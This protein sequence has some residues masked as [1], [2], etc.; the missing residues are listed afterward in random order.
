[1]DNLQTV[2]FTIKS[3]T[4]TQS[5]ANAKQNGIPNTNT[6]IIGEGNEITPD[7]ACSTLQINK[8]NYN[9]VLIH[10]QVY[11]Q[12]GKQG[13]WYKVDAQQVANQLGLST[14]ASTQLA[15]MNSYVGLINSGK[16]SDKGYETINGMKLRHINA[17]F[18]KKALQDL[19]NI[20]KNTSISGVNVGEAIKSVKAFNGEINAWIDEKS[21][22][23]YR[24][25]VKLDSKVDLAQTT[26][27]K[28]M[29]ATLENTTL[30][31]SKFNQ[32]VNIQA[33]TG[34]TPINNLNGLL[35]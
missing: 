30:D 15:D 8:Q 4:Q 17:L 23:V 26:G 33:P 11:V 9:E 28:G 35:Q 32:K 5:D 27:Q 18:D 2:H 24:T 14:L 21:G 10:N 3:S 29:I 31:L 12:Q 22:Y 16:I 6:A 34:A 20:N 25:Q 13:Q 7:Q 1:M 19:Y